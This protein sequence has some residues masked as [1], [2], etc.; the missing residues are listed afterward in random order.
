MLTSIG[1]PEISD[2]ASESL[3][4]AAFLTKPIKQSHLYN[5]LI[6][7]LGGQPIHVKPSRSTSFQINRQLAAQLPLRI[8]LA[9]DNIVNQK[10]ALHLLQLVGY[11]A[12]VASNGLEVLEAL[13]RQVYDVVLMDVQMPHMDGLATTRR[14]CQEWSNK[15]ADGRGIIRPRIIAM[16]A[17]A[18]QGDT[19][20]CLQAGMDDYISKPIR[21]EELIQA[22]SKCQ[23]QEGIRD[24]VLGIR[25][26]GKTQEVQQSAVV[27]EPSPLISGIDA[28]VL[29]SFREMVKENVDEILVEMIDCY[30]EDAPKQLN[31]IATA[32]TQGDAKQLRL[33]AHTLK[34][35]SL[36]LGATTLSHLC[37]ELESTSRNGHTEGGASKIPQLEAEYEKVK[38]A[39]QLERQQAQA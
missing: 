21:V 38:I 15:E 30:L 34:S 3:E 10:V 4:L 29:Q 6:N 22:L 27:L 35:S 36:T 28:K 32:I 20:E 7:I 24:W 19:E 33:A 31:A 14:I 13:H 26:D 1:R 25:E 17:N 8:L 23:P 5:V 16:T 2:R 12:D 9:E 11:R 39:L 37:K 18:M